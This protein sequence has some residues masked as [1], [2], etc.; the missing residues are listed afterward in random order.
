MLIAACAHQGVQSTTSTSPNGTRMPAAG[1]VAGGQLRNASD[2]S[3]KQG[4]LTVW[5]LQ[6]MAQKKQYDQLNALF[7]SGVSLDSLPVGYAAGTGARVLDLPTE[8]GVTVLDSLTGRSWRG[9]IFFKSGD[10]RESHGLNRINEDI[11]GITK[12]IMPMAAFTTSLLDHS[13]LVPDVTSNF[14]VL[15][16]AH[17]KTKP[18][19]LEIAL[20]GIQVYDVMVAVPGKYGPVYVGKTW[21]G[22]YDQ[23]A[24]FTPFET[25]ILVAWYFLDFNPDALSEQTANHW[26]NSVE[27]PIDYGK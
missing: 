21:L 25:N 10:P 15:N 24:V 11:T 13:T 9:K 27:T 19:W 1:D 4:D 17:P 23:N 20:Q 14:V 8:L 6:E 16:Y 2:P 7:N 5:K 22:R 26:D 12:N 3:L 18:Y